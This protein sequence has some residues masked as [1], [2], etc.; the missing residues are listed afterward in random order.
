MF[1]FS[2]VVASQHINTN[3]YLVCSFH[4][5]FLLTVCVQR[6]CLQ[7]FVH[8]FLA[9]PALE[10]LLFWTLYKQAVLLLHLS[11]DEFSLIR[12]YRSIYL[13][14]SLLWKRTGQSFRVKW[15]KQ[16]SAERKRT[17]G[18]KKNEL[19]KSI[20]LNVVDFHVYGTL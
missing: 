20:K 12:R 6:P 19:T 2:G 7:L 17:G 3:L 18:K 16:S 9:E 4:Y 13:S 1:L 8:L 11:Q 14:E 5:L 10:A 15:V